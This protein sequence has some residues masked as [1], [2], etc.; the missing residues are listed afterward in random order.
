M[1]RPPATRTSHA[2]RGERTALSVNNHRG[3]YK[4]VVAKI[5]ASTISTYTTHTTFGQSGAS[6]DGSPMGRV[7]RHTTPD[8]RTRAAKAMEEQLAVA[9]RVLE[10]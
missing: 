6:R 10:T 8:M 2:R 7:H 9:L 3:V 1:G 4:R 5:K